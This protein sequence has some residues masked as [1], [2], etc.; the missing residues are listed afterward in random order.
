MRLP[1]RLLHLYYPRHQ[2]MA[3]LGVDRRCLSTRHALESLVHVANGLF[4]VRQDCLENIQFITN[5]LNLNG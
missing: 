2:I 4:L 5:I 1:R 3:R